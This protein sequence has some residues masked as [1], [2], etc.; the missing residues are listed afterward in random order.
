MK[1]LSVISS[2][3][4]F[5]TFLFFLLNTAFVFSDSAQQSI[6]DE[7]AHQEV[8]NLT[9]EADFEFLRNNPRSSDSHKAKLSFKDKEKNERNYDIKIK[10]RGAFRRVRCTDFPPMKLNF[11]KSTLE[12]EGLLPFD[13]FKLVTQC[14][15]DDPM[16]KSQLMKEYLAYKLYNEL[17]DYSF[18]V[19]LLRITYMDVSTGKK[20]KQWAFLIEDTAEL[21]HRMQAEK[22]EAL[23]NLPADSFHI[24]QARMVAVFQYMIGNSDWSFG[25]AKNLKYLKKKDKIIPVPYDFDFSGLVEASYANPNTNLGLTSLTER[26]YLGFSEDLDLLHGTVYYL[27]GHRAKF[28]SIIMDFRHLSYDDKLKMIDY[29]NE[30]FEEPEC[31]KK[32]EV[33]YIK[34]K[35]KVT[36]EVVRH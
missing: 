34:E 33:V 16:A 6:F 32:P 13:D 5:L 26:V 9:I 24:N 8:V 36:K 12:A 31:F 3:A 17:S 4:A 1:K 18:R 21:R 2:K 11:K 29:L 15:A 14:I 35:E 30:F 7:M 22:G 23:F 10:L 20:E 19:Q 25:T 27:I 28:E